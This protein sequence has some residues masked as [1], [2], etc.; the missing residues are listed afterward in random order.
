MSSSRA[1]T[2]KPQVAKAATKPAGKGKAV[3]K[4]KPAVEYFSTDETPVADSHTMDFSLAGLN[5]LAQSASG[6][7]TPYRRRPGTLLPW[8]VQAKLQVGSVND[9]LE[10]EAD[11]AAERVM[12]MS[13]SAD[14]ALRLRPAEARLQRKAV[15]DMPVNEA[16]ALAH[17][18]LRSPGQPLDWETR[19]FFESRF[20]CDFSRVRV[21]TDTG[22][23]HSAHSVQALAYTVGDRMVFGSGQYAPR[24]DSGRRLIAHELAHTIQQRGGRPVSLQR[25]VTKDFEKLRD[26]LTRGFFDWAVTDADAHKSL[27]LLK[28]LNATDLRD[29]VAAMEK[30]GWVDT[31]FSNV[32]DEDAANET[33]ILEKIN[34]VRV[35]KG[36]KGQPDLV[37][38]CDA[39]QRKAIDDRVAG[40]KDWAREAKNRVNAFAAD[41]A[42]HADTLKLLD[43]HFFHQK[44]NGPRTP[45]DQVNDARTIAANFQL[46]ETQQS[47]QP[48]VCASPFD[49]LCSALALAYGD[50]IKRRIVFCS[51]YFDSTQERQVYNLLHEF[52]HEFAGVADRGYGDERIFAYLTPA[53]S[54]NNADSYALFAVDVNDKEEKSSDIRTAPHDKVSD[55]G[56]NEPEVRRRFAFATRMIT[57]ALNIVGSPG[58]GVAEAQT[59][60]KTSDRA[61]LQQVIE[62]FKK[63]NEKFAGGVNFECESKCDSGTAYWRTWGWTVHLC[64]AWFKLPNPDARTDDILLTAISEELGM[65]YGPAVG[66]PAY[67]NLSQKKAYDSA[68]AYVG[69]AR[70]VTKTFFP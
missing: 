3:A 19:R 15:A 7:P 67:A 27:M 48:N 52:M 49:P 24:T 43:T 64:P 28:S 4:A 20:T 8:P 57:N 40:T 53:D 21:H 17:E 6:D 36:G 61:K 59:H 56:G 33:E 69:Y 9:P 55:C 29:T 41:P 14:A 10:Q 51:S 60:F 65:D 1:L 54:I 70:D 35:H 23:A 44:T 18:V 34:D 42:K 11:R 63:I 50:P 45:A 37:G 38:P 46:A 47:P 68:T 2:F 62:R 22:A 13:E 32:S 30:K 26:W 58:Y 66:S 16:P 31:L 5:I 25:A 12:R 39:K